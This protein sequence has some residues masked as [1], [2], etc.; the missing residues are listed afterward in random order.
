MAD[1]KAYEEALA[2]AEARTVAPGSVADLERAD[3]LWR[4]LR[5]SA[6]VVADVC[7]EVRPT[8]AKVASA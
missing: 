6:K 4:L 1:R 8:L 5:S 2:V 3:A 7:E